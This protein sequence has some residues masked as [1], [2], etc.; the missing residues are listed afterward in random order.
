MEQSLS[1][2]ANSHSAGQEI[3]CSL[4]KAKVHHRA[5]KSP[6]LVLILSQINH[7]SL[8]IQHPTFNNLSRHLT[9]T[10][11]CRINYQSVFLIDAVG[12]PRKPHC[13]YFPRKRQVLHRLILV[14]KISYPVCS[15]CLS[16]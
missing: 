8:V 10:V 13:I 14:Q 3:L 11:M 15:H 5:H 4:W 2:K 6:P 1:L 9:D 16:S 12:H 7:Y